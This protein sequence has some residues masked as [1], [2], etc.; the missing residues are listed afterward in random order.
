MI[1]KVS[2]SSKLGCQKLSSEGV[3]LDEATLEQRI[4]ILENTVD[5][6]KRRISSISTSSNWLDSVIGSISDEPA[7]LEAMEYGKSLRQRK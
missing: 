6:L 2:A 1:R 4:A 5:D 7:F 3:M